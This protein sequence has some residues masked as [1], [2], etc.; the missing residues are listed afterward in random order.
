MNGEQTTHEQFAQMLDGIYT[1]LD[2]LIVR[3]LQAMHRALRC[4]RLEFFLYESE[5]RMLLQKK[6]L[7]DGMILEGEDDIPAAENPYLKPLLSRRKD[8]LV[9]RWPR[10]E[11]WAALGSEKELLGLVWAAQKSAPFTPGELEQFQRICRP[12]ANALMKHHLFQ[13][14]QKQNAALNTFADITN[15]LVSN[16][17][18]GEMLKAVLKAILANFRFDL[19][20]IYLVED[21]GRRL[22]G[23]VSGDFRGRVRA[24]KRE[25]Y[26]MKPGTNRLVNLAL[27]RRGPFVEPYRDIGLNI[28]LRG[29]GKTVGIMTVN[30]FFSQRRISNEERKMLVS[31]SGQIAMSVLGARLFEE[32]ERLSMTDGMTGLYVVRYFK[33]RFA[34]EMNRAKRFNFPL[35]LIIIDLDKFKAINDTYGHQAGDQVLIRISRI[36]SANVR[37]YDVAARYGGDEF[38]VLL[39]QTTSNTSDAIARRIWQQ[40]RELRVDVGPMQTIGV[41]ASMGVATFP[42]DGGDL[43]GLLKHADKA[44]YKSKRA[45]RDR[46]THA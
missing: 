5:S 24:L 41:S 26:A 10:P 42:Q 23:M 22:T 46:I 17:Y 30:N 45:G 31:V 18:R 20:K 7:Q 39:P 8:Q 33:E 32:V 37:R 2:R 43:A 6:I 19:I 34:V 27:S 1:D 38:V 9:M 3:S 35:S 4:R 21:D 16:R 36:I 13:K 40:I 14:S 25:T 12:V 29:K 15:V 44:L 11:I 28:C